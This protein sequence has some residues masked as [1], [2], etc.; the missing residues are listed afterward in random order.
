MT[1]NKY[2]KY[3]SKNDLNILNRF[4]NERGLSEKTMGGYYTAL[5][6]YTM[7][8]NMNLQELLNEADEEEEKGIRWKKS[9]LKQK[10]LGFRSYL[11]TEYTHGTVKIHFGRIKTFYNHF[12][13]DMGYIP[14]INIK[15]VKK[16]EPIRFD[17]LLTKTELKQ[18]C[19]NTSPIMKAIILFMVSSG[20]A[21]KEM[22]S[23]TIQDFINA[24]EEYHNGGTIQEIVVQLI[25]KDNII[26][27]F[28]IRRQ[29]TNKF[30]YT[31]CSP[32]AVKY[33]CN[34]LIV[35][36]RKFNDYTTEPLFKTNRDYLNRDFKELNDKFE[37]G[38]VSGYNKVRSHMFRKF[39]ASNLYDDGMSIED[40]DSIQGRGK[41]NTHQSYF[42][43]NPVKLKE[44]Y[45]QHLKAVTIMEG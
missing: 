16:N 22:M 27:T 13:I 7:Y 9:K 32:E 31:F 38:K 28:K 11:L 25:H 12:E 35:S 26:P 14:K 3:L 39:N 36:A 43:D 10:L 45:S 24:T 44:K 1:K 42:K 15:S 23:I 21:R 20:C 29:K 8:C 40:I 33:I 37:L 5:G 19:D 41:D 18:I 17:D 2:K 6:L 4:Q 34:Y 30:Y